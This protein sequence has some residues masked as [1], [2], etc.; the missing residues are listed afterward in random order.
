MPKKKEESG[1]NPL[2]WML[3]F[4]DLVT[5]LLTFFVMLL[6]MKQPEISKLKAAFGVFAGGAAGSLSLTDSAK[7]Q[8]FERLMDSLRQPS[9]SELTSPQERLAQMLDLP[10]SQETRLT[11]SMQKGIIFQNEPRGLVITLANDL[12]FAP[13]ASELSPGAREVLKRVSPML[14]YSSQPISIEGHTDALPLGGA[15]PLGDN[16]ALAMTRAQNVRNFLQR[17]LKI[18]PARMRVASLG[19]TRPVA[20][21]TTPAGRAKNRRTEIIILMA[22]Y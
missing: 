2:G 18:R 12:L 22:D 11:T 6:S 20:P 3:T 5:L 8:Q 4:S 21:N 19:D 7:V 10:G 1:F 9:V 16:W 13:G 15:N 17:E 14:T